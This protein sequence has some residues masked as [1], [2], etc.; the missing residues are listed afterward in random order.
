MDTK[1]DLDKGQ[2]FLIDKKVLEEEIKLS[3]LSKK[4]IV[5]EIGAGNG[6]LTNR[7][8]KNAGKVKAFEIDKRYEEELVKISKENPNLILIFGDGTKHSWLGANKIVSNIPYHLSEKILRKAGKERIEELILIV[9]EKLKEK[10]ELNISSVSIY[11]NTLYNVDYIR[12]ID[13]TSFSP[14]PRINS[15]LIKLK[16]KKEYS[17]LEKL[18]TNIFEFKGKLKN[19]IIYSLVDQGKTKRAGREFIKELNLENEVLEK[20]PI[21]TTSKIII[22]LKKELEKFI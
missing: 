15:W 18:M 2:H 4:D 14:P 16:L 7:L 10:L 21:N 11:T 8:V 19:A 22:N 17:N 6:V 5:I 1:N 20:S 9:G 12:K 13:K 3:N